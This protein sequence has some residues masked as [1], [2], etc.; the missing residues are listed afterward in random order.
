MGNE[1]SERERHELPAFVIAFACW[2]AAFF[3]YTR[4]EAVKDPTITDITWFPEKFLILTILQSLFSFGSR[5]PWLVL[6]F[7]WI[8][9]FMIFP[10]CYGFETMGFASHRQVREQHIEQIMMLKGF[11]AA[12]LPVFNALAC[13]A[14]L[15][16]TKKVM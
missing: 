3:V 9:A 12:T 14:S 1:L 13:Q 4:F 11:L 7:V 8:F 16:Y 15:S 10:T 5:R 2:F 6:L